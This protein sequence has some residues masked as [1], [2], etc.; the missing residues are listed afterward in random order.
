MLTY[1]TT[2]VTVATN[3]WL[4]SAGLN[5]KIPFARG[6]MV[7]VSPGPSSQSFGVRTPSG[8]GTSSTNSSRSS[9]WG[10]DTIEYARSMPSTPMV[11]YCPGL[12]VKPSGFSIHTDHR[13]SVTSRRRST[14]DSASFGRRRGRLGA[15]VVSL[16]PPPPLP[17]AGTGPCRR[18]GRPSCNAPSWRADRS[19]RGCDRSRGTA[20]SGRS[21]PRRRGWTG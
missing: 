10:A 7:T 18:Q 15:V 5:T 20:L 9:S 6:R 14:F 2:P 11:Q 12:K 4:G 21:R 3:R 1:G 19:R 17:K 13:S 16:I 8:G